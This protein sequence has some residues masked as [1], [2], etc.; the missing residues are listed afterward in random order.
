MKDNNTNGM[1]D[2]EWSDFEFRDAYFIILKS[3]KYLMTFDN[4]G[5]FSYFATRTLKQ[6]MF[7]GRYPSGADSS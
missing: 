1:N 6:F 3:K 2:E 5:Q 4:K 7:Y